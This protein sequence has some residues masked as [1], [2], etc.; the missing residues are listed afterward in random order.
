MRRVAH[1]PV[2][3]IALPPGVT[4]SYHNCTLAS[5]GLEDA[6]LQDHH[7]LFL[8]TQGHTFVY[9]VAA[10]FCTFDYAHL[11]QLLREQGD[12]QF[13]LAA[14]QELD[15]N[16]VRTSQGIFRGDVI[17]DATGWRAALGSG[18]Q[19]DLVRLHRLNFGLETTVAYQD[20][21]L[22]FWYAPGKLLPM[23]VTWAFPIG[24][25]SRIG[26]ASY[27]GDTR[28]GPTLDRFLADLSLR[29]DGLHGGYFPHALRCSRLS[30]SRLF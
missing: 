12:A 8:H 21:G 26:I 20:D 18:Q 25:F 2:G 15:G 1:L 29:R 9:P 22:H 28:L 10:P 13:A 5:L 7:R 24:E 19:P 11:C 30:L 27:R 14:A 3:Q 17:V 16:R 23:G 4:D 6:I